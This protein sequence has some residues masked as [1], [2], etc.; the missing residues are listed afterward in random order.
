VQ[1]YDAALGSRSHV[2][3]FFW[4]EWHEPSKSGG[5]MDSAFEA[6]AT[7]RPNVSFNKIEAEKEET[8]IIAEKLGISVV[9]TFAFFLNGKL[10]NKLEGANPQGDD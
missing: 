1:E 7:R 8:A 9:P 3:I 10:W 2:L 6:L 4:A 5:Q